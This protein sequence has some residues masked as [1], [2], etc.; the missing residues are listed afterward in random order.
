VDVLRAAFDYT[1][2]VIR[3]DAYSEFFAVNNTISD[4]TKIQPMSAVAAEFGSDTTKR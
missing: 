1:K 2:P 4:S 3:P